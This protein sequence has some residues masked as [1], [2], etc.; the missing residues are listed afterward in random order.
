M[1]RA[2][3]ILVASGCGF[4]YGTLGPADAADR[5]G[6]SSSDARLVDA[7]IGGDASTAD[8]VQVP[9]GSFMRGCNTGVDSECE[10]DESPYRAITLSAF[11]IDRTEVTFAAWTACVGSGTCGAAADPGGPDRPVS[12]S[13]AQAQV[14]CAFAGKRLPTEAEW[15]KAAR[16]TDGR[17]YPWGSSDLDCTHANI[18]G[19][20][21][22]VVAVGTYPAGASPYGALD[23]LG[24][25]W[26][27]VAD[28]YDAT[29][30]TT[31][32]DTDPPG[33]A[34]NQYSVRR[35]GGIVSDS[36]AARVSNRGWNI[37]GAGD[38]GVRCAR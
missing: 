25:V 24:N 19:C 32:P 20:G 34:T 14:Y 10:S 3:A 30:Y 18:G 27:W 38:H 17:K 23:M 36:I 6:E 13:H 1:W 12:V 26:E 5:D 31:S 9:A 16:G 28:S 7:R 21:G 4:E 37:P 35:G 8:M 2:L 15:E 29:Y 33:P 11:W 22:V